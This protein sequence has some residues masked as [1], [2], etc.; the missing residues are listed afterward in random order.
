MYM[1]VTMYLLPLF[2]P[3][4]EKNLNFYLENHGAVVNSHYIGDFFQGNNRLVH[5]RC[6]VCRVETLLGNVFISLLILIY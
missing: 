2:S 1:H 5:V 3:C 4:T 6:P